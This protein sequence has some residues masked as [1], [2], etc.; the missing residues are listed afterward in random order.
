MSKSADEQSVDEQTTGAS[1]DGRLERHPLRS[2]LAFI[3]EVLVAIVVALVVTSLLRVYVFQV[4]RV[5]SGSMEQTLELQDRIAAVRVADWQRGDVVVFEDANGWVGAQPGSTN[6]V[7]KTLEKLKL[8]PDST[9]GYLVKRVIGMPGD[10]VACCDQERRI[11][12]NG[13]P[14]SEDYLYRMP[15]GNTVKP[16]DSPFE[17]TVPEGHIFVLGDHRNRSGDSRLHVCRG[18]PM[19][20]FIPTE[21]VV[22]PVKSVL[23][24]ASRFHRL[25]TPDTFASVPPPAGAAPELAVLGANTCPR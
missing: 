18:N 22:G 1:A 12:V 3:G 10:K 5:P 9:Q 21:A 17:V 19:N 25:H 8:L 7:V 23:L 16:S 15:D 6:P 2:I 11:T 20:G 13:Q 24:P 4:F 14:L